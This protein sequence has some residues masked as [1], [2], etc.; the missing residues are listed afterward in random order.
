MYYTYRKKEK[1]SQ[2]SINVVVTPHFYERFVERL[3]FT[4]SQVELVESLNNKLPQGIVLRN[5]S[6]YFPEC[7]LVAPTAYNRATDEVIVKTL[8]QNI[9]KCKNCEHVSIRWSYNV[10]ESDNSVEEYSE[11]V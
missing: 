3:N 6:L 4:G 7:N 2:R 8:L 9:R 1:K 11:E 5:K 10:S